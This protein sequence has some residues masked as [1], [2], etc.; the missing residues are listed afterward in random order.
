MKKLRYSSLFIALCLAA[1]PLLAEPIQSTETPRTDID[2]IP[3]NDGFDSPT[4]ASDD[5]IP[6]PDDD[7]QPSTNDAP[8]ESLP[9]SEQ[10]AS[11]QHMRNGQEIYQNFLAGLDSPGCDTE[12]SNERWER[13]FRND[14]LRLIDA[15]SNIL[16]LFG[17]VVDALRENHLPTEY[18]LIP[19]IESGYRAHPRNPSGPAGLWQFITTTARNHD[20]EVSQHYDGRL[21]P[22]DSTRAAVGYLKKLHGMFDGN[23]RL[24]AMAYNVGEYRILQS[25][26]QAGLSAVDAE[27]GLLSNV[28]SITRAYV[29]KLHALTCVLENAAE[30]PD[31]R[32]ALNRPVPRFV[33]QT[34]P[35]TGINLDTW[36]RQQGHDPNLLRSLNPLLTQASVSRHGRPFVLLAPLSAQPQLDRVTQNDVANRTGTDPSAEMLASLSNE[37]DAL[38]TAPP[39]HTVRRGESVW[40]IA[41]HYGV[42]LREL[43]ALNGLND[44]ARLKPG[45]VLKLY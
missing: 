6:F 40:S 15:D 2:S 7:R 23:W 17:Y 21:S 26:R 41:R 20:V 29:E 1:A 14:S 3:V 12:A 4:A 22:V 10:D 11:L 30:D 19:F 5:G 9:D 13:H 45:M 34:L 24:A 39:R 42:N 37:L 44:S 18:A 35:S 28:P 27:P 8:P 16:P 31:W 38:D 25:M 36:V 43:L 32:A 33:P